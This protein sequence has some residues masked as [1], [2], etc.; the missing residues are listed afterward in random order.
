LAKA[1]PPAF[2]AAGE[3]KTRRMEILRRLDYLQFGMGV[4]RA[5]K[6]S[7]VTEQIWRVG[8]TAIKHRETPVYSPEET[9]KLTDAKL[10]P[11]EM[12]VLFSDMLR[13]ADLLSEED[14]DGKWKVEESET[15]TTFAVE[16]RTKTFV[17]PAED[18]DLMTVLLVG[19]EHEAE[20]VNQALIDEQLAETLRI[21][22]A[23]G[24]RVGM[25]REGGANARQRRAQVRLFGAA[26]AGP[27]LTYAKA[28]QLLDT[29]GDDP[30]QSFIN[31]VK[32]FYDE[33]MSL[34]PDAREKNAKEA[35]DRVLRL[36]RRGRV[37][38]QPLAYAEEWLLI[39]ALAHEKNRYI[40]ERAARVTTLDFVDQARLHR[41]GLLPDVNDV[42]G[43]TED[44]VQETFA[45]YIQKILMSNAA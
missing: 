26:Q 20:H 28:R 33:K 34:V 2:A 6:A 24:K 15:G 5:G 1:L 37:N 10:T 3:D 11:A 38:S 44:I 17:V 42:Q 36:E 41:F 39:D 45:P 21:A 18:K 12:K 40:A 30:D 25:L 43:I 14:G 8:H 7:A 35:V 9:K 19:A 31:A 4:D 23:K 29:S 22:G 13:K 16:S 32:V 27:N